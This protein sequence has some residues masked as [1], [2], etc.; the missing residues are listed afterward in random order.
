MSSRVQHRAAV[1]AFIILHIWGHKPQQPPLGEAVHGGTRAVQV[2][3]CSG[4]RWIDL[5][6]FLVCCI[7]LYKV[8]EENM[9]KRR[10]QRWN[11]F[12]KRD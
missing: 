3:G 2:G 11:L 6:Q 10:L 8:I 7:K 1:K 4:Q 12:I 9:E 5:L